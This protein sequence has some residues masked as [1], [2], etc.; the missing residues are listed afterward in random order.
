MAQPQVEQP[1]NGLSHAKET[2]GIPV[3]EEILD[4][5][6]EVFHPLNV[7]SSPLKAKLPSL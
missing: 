6:N 4:N 3:T 1:T 2:V 5:V 7:R